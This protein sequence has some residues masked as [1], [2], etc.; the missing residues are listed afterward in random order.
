[1]GL[2][3]MLIQTMSKGVIAYV[4]DNLRVEFIQENL[5]CTIDMEH[6]TLRLNLINVKEIYIIRVYHPPSGNINEFI[7]CM[8]NVIDN[9]NNKININVNMIGDINT[10]I[11]NLDNP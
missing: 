11:R 6:L 5:K 2:I 4:K 7:T 8:D 1:M 9:L 3:G 10:D